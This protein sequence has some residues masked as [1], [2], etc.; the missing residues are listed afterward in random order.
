MSDVTGR[1]PTPPGGERPVPGVRARMDLARRPGWRSAD[2]VRAVAL[3]TAVV[4][5]AIGLWEASTV[6]FTVFL[7]I[8]FGLAIS[9]GV[10]Y[11]ARLHIPRGVGA[12]LVVLGVAGLL[13]L[14]GAAIAPTV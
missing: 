8:L 7:G 10:D 6:V 2:I 4:A 1:S 13:A 3:G 12:L 5:A 14:I 11:L 9:S